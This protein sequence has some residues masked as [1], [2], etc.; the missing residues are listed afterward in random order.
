M[1]ET[2]LNYNPY[3][4]ESQVEVSDQDLTR[5]AQTYRSITGDQLK[6]DF[7]LIKSY[8]PSPDWY[9]KFKKIDRPDVKVYNYDLLAPEFDLLSFLRANEQNKLQAE[10]RQ[11]LVKNARISPTF[12]SSDLENLRL[13]RRTIYTSPLVLFIHKFTGGD[14]Y[15]IIQDLVELSNLDKQSKLLKRYQIFLNRIGGLYEA[16]ILTAPPL[17]HEIILFGTPGHWNKPIKSGSLDQPNWNHSDTLPE[18]VYVPAGTQI[19][20]YYEKL[21]DGFQSKRLHFLLPL[22][23]RLKLIEEKKLIL[24]DYWEQTLVAENE[25]KV[26]SSPSTTP[27]K[28]KIYRVKRPT[29]LRQPPSFPSYSPLQSD[30]T[31]ISYETQ[32]RKFQFPSRLKPEVV[33]TYELN[34]WDPNYHD[35]ELDIVTSYHLRG[36]TADL[37]YRTKKFV[38]REEPGYDLNSDIDQINQFLNRYLPTQDWLTRVTK[39]TRAGNYHYL[40]LGAYNY[41]GDRMINGYIRFQ[42][43]LREFLLRYIN[44]EIPQDPLEKERALKLLQ[45]T[46]IMSLMAEDIPPFELG[47]MLRDLMAEKLNIDWDQLFAD[48]LEYIFFGSSQNS[49]LQ[50][51]DLLPYEFSV[52]LQNLILEAPPLDQELILFRGAK[53]EVYDLKI[54]LGE[55][56]SMSGIIST[57]ISL[58]TA[59]RFGRHIY[60]IRVPAGYRVLPNNFPGLPYGEREMILPHRSKFVLETFGNLSFLE[61]VIFHHID[62]PGYPNTQVRTSLRC[63]QVIFYFCRLIEQPK[64]G[65]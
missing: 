13:I 2:L 9:E 48:L 32:F 10:I 27:F 1:S 40:L 21:S 64:V 15:Y 46:D 3:E 25:L 4:G 45:E 53:E 7:D 5:M 58:D 55:E 41:T 29:P 38:T 61:T 17:D 60:V 39:Y 59:T 65:P 37:L 19:L 62:D 43:T 11:Y 14:P 33:Y 6:S 18:V 16:M 8:R 44:I 47:G 50:V 49:A 23:I 52:D 42:L 30:L 51:Y 22:G 54:E 34:F 63:D 24:H 35:E 26:F 36:N 56:F 57:S 12:D 31:T 20:P 28:I